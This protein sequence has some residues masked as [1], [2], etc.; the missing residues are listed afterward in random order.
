[1]TKYLRHNPKELAR[2]TPISEITDAQVWQYMVTP[3]VKALLGPIVSSRIELRDTAAN[4]IPEDKVFNQNGH[5]INGVEGAVRF[6]FYHSLYT[7]RKG[8]LIIRRDGVK[9][10]VLGWFGNLER[11]QGQLIWKVAL[12][13]RRY[14]GH[15]STND[16]AL[17]HFPYDDQK[18]NGNFFPGSA[19]A[20]IYLFS[21]LPGSTI[22]GACGDEEL[23]KFVAQPFAYCDRPELFL[24]LFAKAWKS[25]RAPGQW[26]EPINDAGDIMEDNFTELC[27]KMGYD[28]EEVAASH[29]HVAMWCKATGYVFTDPVQDA[30]MNALIEGGRSAESA[31]RAHPGRALSRR[32]QVAAGQ[33]HPAQSLALEAA[34]R[35]GEGSQAQAGLI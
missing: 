29:Y 7:T 15:K 19:S 27:S 21:Y 28:L 2:Q 23:E 9:V 20:E 3:V 8:C 16:C 6:P 22:V 17:E 13:D 12:R 34:E 14:D 26:S 4:I 35:K 30:N 32:C 18:L 5:V 11:K 24:K 10:E 25:N 33:Y 1:M 31:G